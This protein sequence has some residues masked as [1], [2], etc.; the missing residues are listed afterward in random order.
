MNIF[1][2][3]AL[4]EFIGSIAVVVTLVFLT[5][6]IRRSSKITEQGNALANSTALDEGFHQFSGFRRL[7]IS[8][9]DV[10]RIWFQGLNGELDSE[11][12][13]QRFFQLAA[14]WEVILRNNYLRQKV[15]GNKRLSESMPAWWARDIQSFPGLR[16]YCD[17]EAR[18]DQP[19]DTGF[20]AAVKFELEKLEGLAS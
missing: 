1:E 7:L 12:D 20:Y 10:T 3:G 14:E 19:D 8:D 11:I 4:G 5:I 13:D 2:L 17:S 18:F 6:Q 16:K 15:V 9:P